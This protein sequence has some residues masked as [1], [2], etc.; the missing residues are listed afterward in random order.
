[1]GSGPVKRHV[2]INYIKRLIGLPEETIAIYRGKL[3]VLSPESGLHYDE[4]D[5]ADDPGAKTLLWQLRYTHHNDPK[6]V[7]KFKNGDFK[8]VRKNPENLLTM[9]RLVYNNDHQ[10]RDLKDEKYQRWVAAQNSGWSSQDK[11]S[12]SN[13]GSNSEPAWLR[14]RH[15]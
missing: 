15:V 11:K 9:R 12:F 8:I 4:P 3:W 6:A 7:E 14:Y 1:P 10:A 13:D 5:L 2:P